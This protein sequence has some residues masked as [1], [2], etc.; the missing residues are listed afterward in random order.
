[1]HLHPHGRGEDTININ[2]NIWTMET[3]PRAWGRRLKNPLRY[4]STRNTPTGVGKTT[5]QPASNVP[6]EK[7]PHG[8]GEDQ[9]V[10]RKTY[11]FLE[12]PPRAWGRPFDAHTPFFIFRN[13]PT[14]VG[15]TLLRQH[16]VRAGGKHP[17]GRGEDQCQLKALFNHLETPPRAWGRQQG[18]YFLLPAIRNTPTGVGKTFDAHTPIDAN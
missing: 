9:R 1:M 10:N 15:K 12:T 13:T 4:S 2:F 17:H 8:R 6:P 5:S 18:I 16:I 11:I 14:G 7:H 3:P